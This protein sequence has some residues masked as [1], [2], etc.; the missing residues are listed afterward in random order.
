[1]KIKMFQSLNTKLKKKKKMEIT[2]KYKKLKKHSVKELKKKND[3]E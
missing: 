3:C 1:M 2:G